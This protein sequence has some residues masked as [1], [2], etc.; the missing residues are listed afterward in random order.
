MRGRVKCPSWAHLQ[1]RLWF[2]TELWGSRRFLGGLALAAANSWDESWSARSS[3][4]AGG[5]YPK[6][7]EWTDR[8]PQ[9]AMAQSIKNMHAP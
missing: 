1:P 7:M 5:G 9:R 3:P 8:S 6:A 2:V 4:L